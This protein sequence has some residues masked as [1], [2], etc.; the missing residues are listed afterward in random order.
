MERCHLSLQV[1]DPKYIPR[2]LSNAEKVLVGLRVKIDGSMM[3]NVGEPLKPVKIPESITNCEDA[4]SYMDE[5]ETPHYKRRM[6]AIGYNEN[7]VSYTSGHCCSD[8]S[9]LIKFADNCLDDDIGETPDLPITIKE[10]YGKLFFDGKKYVDK[11]VPADKVTAFTLRPSDGMAPHSCRAEYIV[12]SI[13]FDQ[14]QVYNRKT[15]NLEG[16][17]NAI[18]SSLCL[19]ISTMENK[20]KN[21]LCVCTCIDLRRFAKEQ[22][23]WSYANQYSIMNIIADNLK[24]NITLRNV[25]ESFRKDL[26]NRIEKGYAFS[27]FWG[28]FI[29]GKGSAIAFVS[30]AGPLMIKKPFIDKRIRGTMN[31]EATEFSLSLL[32]NQ[33]I[34]EHSKELIIRQR[35]SP[36]AITKK[37]ATLITELTKYCITK[38]PLDKKLGDAFNE[39]KQYKAKLEKEL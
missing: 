36:A 38:I 31:G 27:S 7:I 25:N 23:D 16:L 20:L 39:L 29:E 37:D 32:T 14:L 9:Y 5:F 24:K 26:K 6:A 17:N 33:Q 22:L 19:A 21:H 3:Y 18:N 10:A 2:I 1:E 35:Y 11:M 4:I 30:H 12:R 15:K 34:Y 13:P 28:P 8:G